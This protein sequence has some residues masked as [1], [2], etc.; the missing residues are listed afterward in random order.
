MKGIVVIIFAG[1]KCDF[2]NLLITI[3]EAGA[4]LI[5]NSD[6]DVGNWRRKQCYLRQYC[7]MQ[8]LF[9]ILYIILLLVIS[10]SHK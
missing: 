8:K 1:G 2:I 6:E 5:K 3:Y 10:H 4:I 7:W 9:H